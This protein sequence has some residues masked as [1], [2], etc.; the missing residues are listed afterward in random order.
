[1]TTGIKHILLGMFLLLG[2]SC[3]REEQ[4]PEPNIYPGETLPLNI[5]LGSRATGDDPDGS[6]TSMRAIVFNDKGQLVCNEV[7]PAAPDGNVYTAQAKAAR[8]TNHFYIICNETEELAGKLGQVTR[9]PD[10]E[11][12]TFS[13]VG[14]TAPAP[15]YGKVTDVWV[16]SDSDGSN[17]QV[18]VNNVT[19]GV[20]PVG[21]NRMA[22][23]FSFT[24][25]KNITEGEDFTVTD[26]RI[27]VCRMPAYTTIAE[28]IYTDSKWSDQITMEKP[29]LLD[30][31][32]A[33]DISDNVY[34]IPEGLDRIEFPDIYIPE[35][36]LETSADRSRATYLKIEARCRMKD[37]TDQIRNVIY[38]VNIGEKPP[39]NHDLKRNNH[40][41]IYATITGLGAMGI[42][43][44]IVPMDLY[45]IPV[46]WKP[47]EG[48]VIVS[49]KASDFDFDTGTSKNVNVW[50]DYNVYSGI[51]KVYHENIGYGDLLFRYGSVVA[52]SNN[53]ADLGQGFTAPTAPETLNDIL[54]YPSSYGNPYSQITG[55][56]NIPYLSSGDIPVD[57]SRVR[58]GLGDPCK[59]AGLS[60]IQI[61]DE[62]ITDNGQWHMATPDE[63]AL[64]VSQGN[65]TQ[66]DSGYGSFHLLHIPNVNYRD[67]SGR[68]TAG[69][70]DGG[71]YWTTT[72]VSAFGFTHTPST[73]ASVTTQDPGRGYTIRCVRNVIPASEMSVSRH[74]NVSY[75]GNTTTGVTFGILSN[76][77][78]WTATLIESGDDAGT[79]TEPDDFS[80]APG[81]SVVH[82]TT[83]NYNQNIPVYVKRKESLTSRTFRVKVEGTGLDGNRLSKI[84]TVTQDKY[85]LW[86]RFTNLDKTTIPQ[87]GITYNDLQIKLTPDDIAFPEG[88][89]WIEVYYNKESIAK[90]Q[91]L[92]TEPNKYTYDGFSVTV[93]ANEYPDMRGLTFEIKL[94]L[95]DAELTINGNN[96][97]I[98]QDKK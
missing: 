32:G 91:E 83:G 79:A 45:E 69:A 6:V 36:L 95:P 4:M 49:D 12:I 22:A 50:S 62:G 24:A 21:V 81:E 96:E 93:P 37:G 17:A 3:V 2:A 65:V 23:R 54:W 58:E 44:D 14:L 34:T 90:S 57:N 66:D 18:T 38:T 39:Q 47:I 40:Y 76:I 35:N 67:A 31:N 10:I 41:N 85:T 46:T 29:C 55:W 71:Q 61:R 60:E 74:A 7:A 27:R 19:T 16:S 94:S 75:Q 92:P 84:V 86:G 43:A 42:Y 87:A 25:I 33:Y 13:A 11:Q 5:R 26:L 53:V 68:L 51:L 1:M 59:L 48:L 64:L 28:K 30:K 78:Y 88:D 80:F 20:L 63:Y 98:L 70:D 72:G 56:A 89:L 52:V 77:P 97:H 15:M 9:Q 8:G 82:A 73:S